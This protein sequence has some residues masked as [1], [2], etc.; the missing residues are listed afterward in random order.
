MLYICGRVNDGQTQAYE[1]EEEQNVV[2]VPPLNFI[3]LCRF[4]VPVK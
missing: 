1:Q 2:L 4:P 3:D